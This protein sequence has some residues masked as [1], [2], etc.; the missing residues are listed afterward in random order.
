MYKKHKNR[1]L[2]KLLQFIKVIY[3]HKNILNKNNIVIHLKNKLLYILMLLILNMQWQK[4]IDYK[5]HIKAKKI[6]IT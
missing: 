4:K 5:T 6:V 2:N 3:L 1:K